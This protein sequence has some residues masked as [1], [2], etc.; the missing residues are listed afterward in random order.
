MVKESAKVKNFCEPLSKSFT[1]LKKVV[2]ELKT[3]GLT[4]LGPGLIAAV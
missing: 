3:S 2:G 4:A 1:S